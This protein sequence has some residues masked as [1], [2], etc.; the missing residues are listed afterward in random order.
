M[1]VVVSINGIGSLG[2]TLQIYLLPSDWRILCLGDILDDDLDLGAKLAA[3]DWWWK[4]S[5]D[6]FVSG[7]FKAVVR[8]HSRAVDAGSSAHRLAVLQCGANMFEAVALAMIAIKEKHED[9]AVAKAAFDI[10]IAKLG[11]TIPREHHAIL[12]KH[13]ADLDDAAETPPGG[14]SSPSP[15]ERDHKR[16]QEMLRRALR[17]QESS[18]QYDF[19]CVVPGEHSQR[20]IQDAIRGYISSATILPDLLK[21]TFE[22]I[23]TIYALAGLSECGKST[24]ADMIHKAHGTSGAR[25]KMSYFL[26]RASN[27]LGYDVYSLSGERRAAALLRGLDAFA[28]CHWYLSTLTIESVHRYDSIAALKSY[29]GP[30]LQ[31]IY[32]D[33]NEELRLERSGRPRTRLEQKD[34]AKKGRGAER[35]KEIADVVIDN[36]GPKESL[37][38]AL[39]ALLQRR[40]RSLGC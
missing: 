19:V 32:I 6:E 34:A 27:E 22:R 38:D 1:A 7:I 17:M 11:L 36:N 35:V 29:L 14:E 30:L 16:Y 31:I 21:P 20:Q 12:I 9:L 33:A 39:R 28:R 18:G 2:K 37:E 5:A 10:I 4:S 13:H 24:V 23:K 26:D 40:E 25:L 8:R 3:A 15:V